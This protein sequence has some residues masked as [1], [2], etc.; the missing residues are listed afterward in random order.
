[1]GDL[2]GHSYM[3]ESQVTDEERG[4]AIAA[5]LS[6]MAGTAIP[7]GNVLAPLVIWFIHREKSSFVGKHASEAMVFQIGV[8]VAILVLS[9][10]AV[11]TFGLGI[12]LAIFGIVALLIADMVYMILAAIRASERKI[13]EYPLTTR[14]VP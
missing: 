8:L 9:L 4:W 14:F 13:W 1:M 2:G 10:F 3:A 7:C 6:T 12:V 5:H 11:I